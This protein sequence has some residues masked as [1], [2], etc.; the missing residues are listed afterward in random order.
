MANGGDPRLLRAARNDTARLAFRWQVKV[1]AVIPVLLVVL[2]SLCGSPVPPPSATRT[3][4]PTPTATPWNR[5]QAQP[6]RFIA[7][8]IDDAIRLSKTIFNRQGS[9]LA[10][11]HVDSATY[12]TEATG[13]SGQ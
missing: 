1:F 5:A 10:V 12:N 3:V 13:R 8:N 9:T 7:N 4:A 2:V 11:A 6:T